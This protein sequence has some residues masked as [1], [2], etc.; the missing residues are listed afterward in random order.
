MA[1]NFGDADVGP[2]LVV[3]DLITSEIVGSF[4][5]EPCLDSKVSEAEAK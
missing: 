3:H 2:R 5:P 1:S 4:S